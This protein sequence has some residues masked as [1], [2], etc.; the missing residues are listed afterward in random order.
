MVKRFLATW[1]L[2]SATTC[3]F[4]SAQDVGL[5]YLAMCH[6]SWPCKRSLD[7]YKPHATIVTGWLEQTFAQDCHCADRLLALP[8]P[9][10]VRVHIANGACLR[11]QRCGQY[12]IFAGET[13][14]SANR[15][16]A[17]G[18]RRLLSRYTRVV[19]RLR[20]RLSRAGEVTCY[21]SPCL[22]CDLNERARKVLHN[23]TSDL[24]PSCR[25]VD[26]V[27]GRPCLR[28]AVCEKH[29]AAPRVPRPCITDTDGV[30]AEDID[31]Q[32]FLRVSRGCALAYVWSSGFN[33]LNH[34]QAKFV[35]PRKRDCQKN[36]AP[37]ETLAQYLRTTYE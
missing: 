33:C 30:R 26:S 2:A 36:A 28:D 32:R 17:R 24:L 4:G 35:D 20:E 23:I 3:S 9:K 29:G 5:S 34:H 14:A 37:F 16:V 10:V 15:K 1:L 8:K 7:V 6:P 25:L 18:D 21:V 19:K 12:E 22:E 31:M 27:Y 13:I 11:N